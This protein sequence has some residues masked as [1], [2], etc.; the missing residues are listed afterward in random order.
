MNSPSFAPLNH[1]LDFHYR[2]HAPCHG[3][4]ESFHLRNRPQTEF[5]VVAIFVLTRKSGVFLI[6]VVHSAFKDGAK[7]LDSDMKNSA[8]VF[9][10]LP[11]APDMV[12]AIRK[13]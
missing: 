6:L 7:H 12:D 3:C 13:S 10:P 4:A 9:F 11:I 8:S 2:Q 1:V 5:R